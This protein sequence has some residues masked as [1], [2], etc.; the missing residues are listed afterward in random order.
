[1]SVSSSNPS[2]TEERPPLGWCWHGAN[3]DEEL[4]PVCDMVEIA[5]GDADA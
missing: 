3:L 5:L 4:C 2:T 1:M